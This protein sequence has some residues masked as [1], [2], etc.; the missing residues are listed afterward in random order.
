M[1]RSFDLSFALNRYIPNN[2]FYLTASLN[3]NKQKCIM[4]AQR[5]T[6]TNTNITY[7]DALLES[8]MCTVCASTGILQ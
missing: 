6:N 7:L 3:F 1:T 4:H 5:D 8:C 2:G